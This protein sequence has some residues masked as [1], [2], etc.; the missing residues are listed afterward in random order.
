MSSALDVYRVPL[1]GLNLI[2]ASAG[3]GKTWSLC[4]LYLRLLL[5]KKLEVS[6]ILVV[7]FTNAATS[8][9]RSRIRDRI[10]EALEILRQREVGQVESS[11]DRE[12]V[13]YLDTLA[14]KEGATPA[15]QR[16][17][18]ARECFDEAA[19]FTIHGFC[20]RALA[21]TPFSGGLPFVFEAVED[22][23]EHRLQEA[24][25]FWRSRISSLTAP[26]MEHLLAAGDS[27]AA[28]AQYLGRRLAKPLA[29]IEWPSS[30]PAEPDLAALEA[31][32][33]PLQAAWS[34]G[35]TEP[36]EVLTASLEIL[37]SNSYTA[38][39][40]T[41]GAE[42]W[43]GWLVTGDP[44]HR[45]HDQ[46][47][48][49]F[50]L[51]RRARV[52]NGTLKAHK[53][54]SPSHPFFDAADHFL[55]EQEKYLDALTLKRLQ[56]LREFLESAAPRLRER[57]RQE[58]VVAFNDMLA[59]LHEALTSGENPGLSAA[60][61][62]R[63]PVALID[64]FQDTDPLQFE[65]F[66][67]IHGVDEHLREN[68]VFLV[69]DPKQA[70]YSFRNADLHTYL[71]AASLVSAR[72][73]LGKNHRSTPALV[74]A[75]N[76]IFSANSAAFLQP[77]I[78]FTRVEPAPR[79]HAPLTD[80][81]SAPRRCF[82][83]WW[84][85]KDEQGGWLSRSTAKALC[86][87]RTTAEISRLLAE[88][89]HVQL[90]GRGLR[91]ADIAVLVRTHAEGRLIRQALESRGVSCV[92]MSPSSVYH[93]LEAE[94]LER[95]LI[96]LA[97][98][99]EGLL[100]A[101][102]TVSFMGG[103]A[104]K[105][106]SLSSDSH[107]FLT[108]I[109]RFAEYRQLWTTRG[110][111]VMFRRFLSS[112]RVQKHTLQQPDGERRLTNLLHLGELLSEAATAHPA[113]E[114]LLRWFRSQRQRTGNAPEAAQMRL[115]SD[116]NLVRIVTIH[117][118]KGLEYPVVFCPF[119]WVDNSA[120]R[121]D[122][123][124]LREYH[125]DGWALLDFRPEA[126]ESQAI[127]SR[128]TVEA[129]A[130]FLRLVYVALTRASRRCYLFAGFCKDGNSQKCGQSLRSHLNWLVAGNGMTPAQWGDPKQNQRTPEEVE[131]AWH[132]LASAADFSVAPL[133][134]MHVP[135]AHGALQRETTFAL[136]AHCETP[137]RV[138]ETW[139]RGSFTA[140]TRHLHVPDRVVDHDADALPP[141]GLPEPAAL[142][143]PDDILQFPR[144]ANAGSCLH[145]AFELIDF[146]NTEGWEAA[147][148]RAL[149]EFPQSTAAAEHA[150]HK[151][152]LQRM[153]KDVLA[154]PLRED[155]RLC[156]V[157]LANRLNELSFTLHAPLLAVERLNSLLLPRSRLLERLP[158][159]GWQGF[160]SGAIDLV[161]RHAGK[162]YLL[163]W[164]SN[165]LGETAESYSMQA[166]NNEMLR[167][168]YHLQHLLYTV[169]LRRFLRTRLPDYD[170]ASQ[171]GGVFYLFVRAVRPDWRLE[172]G[173]QSGVYFERAEDDLIEAVDRCLDYTASGHS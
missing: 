85:P 90:D 20:Q 12:L 107:A 122:L 153:L 33:A 21:D 159:R 148:A 98:R 120:P 125:E 25:D 130:E 126:G 60:L 91:A 5:E 112:E 127:K 170:H 18:L 140:L 103:S 16:L 27:P 42:E 83:V 162:F 88:R 154:C 109:Q 158:V 135:A 106:L 67:L 168:A 55:E 108:A 166:L 63:F 58:R 156:D 117:K 43:R 111:A 28:Y 49:K 116:A 50:P 79:A 53:S 9:L 165:F 45:P 59:N 143:P 70:I 100:R 23:T 104:E 73:M 35:E 95:V 78:D 134:D 139:V 11:F 80:S 145:R 6:R 46:K 61:R 56:L 34:A 69:G 96:A 30:S 41:Q 1:A 54:K 118:S 167:H 84:L 142:L 37:K 161:F 68:P 51:Y 105:I 4:G 38:D 94:E 121:S 141:P 14:E 22:D 8:E 149:H 24:R 66:R 3:T 40:I 163:D 57:K 132:T 89:D 10:L 87:G 72:H 93:S 173:S 13:E 71:R 32:F 147:I 119:L 65:I 82:E 47:K 86:A 171:F 92:E 31:A 64:E 129:D 146:C 144:G 131:H 169:A 113:P 29:R 76:G 102:L 52:T 172:D 137:P 97:Q 15:R 7:T 75:C 136:K 114:S 19:I 101:A 123:S 39:G 36:P 155:L 26:C 160:L 128:R 77:G 157:P 133:P 152:M 164:K 44:L 151:A 115:E 62:E 150:L 138:C 74:K 17:A 2:E 81:S 124:L 110:F 48:A 99:G